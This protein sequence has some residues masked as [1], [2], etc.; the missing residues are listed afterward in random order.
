MVLFLCLLVTYPLDSVKTRL[1]VA[2]E[3]AATKVRPRLFPLIISTA[4]NEGVFSFWQGLSPA[5]Y[6]HFRK[7]FSKIIKIF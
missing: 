6:R 2:G 1:Q 5:L 4:K 7:I 3:L